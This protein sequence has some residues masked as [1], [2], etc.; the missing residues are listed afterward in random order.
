MWASN[1]KINERSTGIRVEKS[2]FYSLLSDKEEIQ[3][4]TKVSNIEAK[5][6]TILSFRFLGKWK[7]QEH[8]SPCELRKSEIGSLSMDR[9]KELSITGLPNMKIK[10]IGFVSLT[11]WEIRKTFLLSTMRQQSMCK[12][13]N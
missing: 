2:N 11:G 6:S 4:G 3:N 12:L 13:G 8:W 7:F 5:L 1:Q 10:D 9:L